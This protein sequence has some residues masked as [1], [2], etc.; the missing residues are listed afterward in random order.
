MP[1]LAAP[2]ALCLAPLAFTLCLC[3]AA[4]PAG[5]A[6]PSDLTALR[7]AAAPG[8][9]TAD[10]PARS[11]PFAGGTLHAVPCRATAHDQLSVLI[12]ER[13]GTLQ[14]LF[15]A[16]PDFQFQ[17]AADG[18]LDWR[19]P[20]W[21]GV[22]VSP[23]VSTFNADA[24]TGTITVSSMIA[25]GLGQGAFV[26]EHALGDFGV[27]L[28]RA[29]ASFDSGEEVVL[30]PPAAPSLME[31]I[32]LAHSLDG[33]TEEPAPDTLLTD[34]LDIAGV[35]RPDFP[36]AEEGRPRL[37]LSFEQRGD[38]IAANLLD[39]G[40][41]DD[42]VAGRAWRVLMVRDGAGWRITGLGSANICGRGGA[43]VTTGLCP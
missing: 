2:L 24:T 43:R 40:W 26:Y 21:G 18:A 16:N 3:L 14:P 20:Q 31:E 15:F 36:S 38:R 37:A 29:V 1:R 41:A 12:L 10:G 11:Q 19:N 33:F 32:G 17:Y 9:C 39:H 30:W 35:I 6:G 5:A 13:E 28:E 25:P 27:T 42:S 7:D 8:E 22:L 4:A 23:V 34:P